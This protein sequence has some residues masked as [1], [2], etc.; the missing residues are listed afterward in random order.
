MSAR[1]KAW[2]PRT[3][4]PSPV[5]MEEPSWY[6]RLVLRSLKK[7]FQSRWSGVCVLAEDASCGGGGVLIEEAC[8]IEIIDVEVESL[9][10]TLRF[11]FVRGT[12][13]LGQEEESVDRRG[14]GE[15]V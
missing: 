3:K 12:R 4:P 7:V 14:V 9:N 11:A 2:A 1:V 15:A 10:T 8:R 5:P 6:H 13:R